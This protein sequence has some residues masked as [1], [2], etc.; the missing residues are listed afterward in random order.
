MC[1][2]DR[3]YSDL[4]ALTAKLYAETRLDTGFAI[5]PHCVGLQH[6]DEPSSVDFGLWQKDDIELVENMI[7]SIDMPILN[8]GLGGSAHLE[9]L[10]LIG[11]DGPELLNT[12]DDRLIIV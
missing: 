5:N 7:I 4:H 11:K 8:S 3:K 10:V 12:S 2:R 6:T 9:D 1:I